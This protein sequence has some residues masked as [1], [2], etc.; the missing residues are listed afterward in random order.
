MKI[1]D[2]YKIDSSQERQR[3]AENA[4]KARQEYNRTQTI[5]AIIIAVCVG[6]AV[7][8]AIYI[9]SFPAVVQDV[10][11]ITWIAITLAGLVLLFSLEKKGDDTEPDMYIYGMRNGRFLL[12][13]QLYE[14]LG[15]IDPG[16]VKEIRILSAMRPLTRQRSYRILPHHKETTKYEYF[17]EARENGR[18]R[19]Y[20][21]VVLRTG[22][23][24]IN[25]HFIDDPIRRRKLNHL[26][27]FIPM[28]D[29]E[30]HFVYLLQN[31]C[32][33]VVIAP[34]VYKRYREHLDG[35]FARSGM[36][37]NRLKIEEE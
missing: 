9:D 12:L 10:L 37:M 23:K 14:T 16:E 20:P 26:L 30:E 34:K 11:G 3:Y 25:W 4:G 36:D 15:R 29:K 2:R 18:I 24:R 22:K 32:C 13:N 27:T 5:A 33:P 21:M 19:S 8:L 1:Y 35:L 31:S 28:G 17:G 6:F 7:F